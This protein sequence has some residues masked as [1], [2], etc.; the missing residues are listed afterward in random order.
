MFKNAKAGDKV[1]Y[2]QPVKHRITQ[3]T[4]DYVV[5]NG[6]K[7]GKA[8]GESVDNYCPWCYIV[9]VSNGTLRKVIG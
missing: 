1:A 7:F 5:V 4:D 9:N 8:L 2:Y 3:V 6:F